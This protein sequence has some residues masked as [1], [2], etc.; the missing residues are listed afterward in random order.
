MT[1]TE[2]RAA[3]VLRGIV[4]DANQAYHQG[5]PIMTDAQYDAHYREL[6]ALE[7][8]HPELIPGSPT[9]RVGAPVAGNLPKITH[10][11]PMLS[12]NTA[13][14]L[15]EY[16]AWYR[17]LAETLGNPS[18]IPLVGEVKLDGV[19]VSLVY[20][21]GELHTAATRGDGTQGQ[22]IT[23]HA[24]AM[25]S[26]PQSLPFAR[27]C[28]PEWLEVRGEVVVSNEAFQ[29]EAN[30]AYDHPRTA[31]AATLRSKDSANTVQR[32]LEFVAYSTDRDGTPSCEGE[33]W[34][35]LDFGF[36]IP[37][38][39]P[40]TTADDVRDF[41]GNRKTLCSAIPYPADGVVIKVNSRQLQERAGST[42]RAPRWA[43]AVKW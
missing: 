17:C 18:T 1:P 24:R 20:H 3:V 32:G 19:A 27:Y 16:Q 38:A 21:H 11:T 5:A 22:D 30:A 15:Q 33:L 39:K 4:E 12:L 26:V 35:L 8:V 7:R 13:Y 9:Q 2:H 6:Q 29:L 28:C 25:A 37:D 31:A 43:V 23:H 10:R 42:S 41:L 40:L 34:W 14:N 36:K